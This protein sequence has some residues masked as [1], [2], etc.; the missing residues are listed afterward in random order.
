MNGKVLMLWFFADNTARIVILL[1]SSPR[2]CRDYYEMI[3]VYGP[4]PIH[5]ISK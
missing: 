3:V 2:L 4:R 1:V 5:V